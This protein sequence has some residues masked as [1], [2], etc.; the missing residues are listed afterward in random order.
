MSP[1][2]DRSRLILLIALVA[3]ALLLVTG[4]AAAAETAVGWAWPLADRSSTL[5]GFGDPYE[6]GG[7]SRTHTGVD[8]AATEG[9]E[10]LAPVSATASFVG[11]VPSG[12]DRRQKAVTIDTVTGEKLTLMPLDRVSVSVGDHVRPGQTI[13][14]VAA[15][16]D[17]STG[18]VHLHVSMRKG[19]L[20]VDP[21]ASLVV[22]G[23]AAN[24]QLGTD[25][26]PS[27][28]T[29]EDPSSAPADVSAQA[30]IHASSGVA[31]AGDA[32]TPAGHLAPSLSGDAVSVP[33]TQGSASAATPGSAVGAANAAQPATV[34]TVAAGVSAVAADASAATRDL[35]HAAAAADL[36]P[37]QVFSLTDLARIV[38]T[39]D[40]LIVTI[41]SYLLATIAASGLIAWAVRPRV[42]TGLEPVPMVARGD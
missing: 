40:R 12:P 4:R 38:R 23:A 29:A 13:A 30:P 27:S 25:P 39:R 19:S 3:V 7:Q 42:V 15:E 37:R 32:P 21:L 10:V 5:L 31:A 28:Q 22:P 2:P 35:V 9:D 6:S 11:E 26:Q 33:R 41:V 36:T 14:R 24:E 1:A 16:G 20:Y 17:G 18:V 8:L 34:R